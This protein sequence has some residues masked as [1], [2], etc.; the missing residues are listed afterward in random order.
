MKIALIEPAFH[1]EVVNTYIKMFINHVEQIDVYAS[2]G[3]VDLIANTE[4]HHNLFFFTSENETFHNFLERSIAPIAEQYTLILFTTNESADNSSLCCKKLNNAFLLVHNVSLS[5]E[6]FSFQHLWVY[7]RRTPLLLLKM[8]KSYV[9]SSHKIRTRNIS[10]YNNILF[11]AKEILEFS[12]EKYGEELK[13]KKLLSADFFGIEKLDLS[14]GVL[15][16]IKIV[17]PGTVESKTRNYND[18]IEMLEYIPYKDR[19][20]LVLLGKVANHILLKKIL[21]KAK[22]AK[23]IYNVD[24]FSPKEYDL[25]LK[26]ANLAVLPLRKFM[27]QGTTYELQGQTCLSGSINDVMRFGLPFLYNSE[28][29]IPEVLKSVSE[30]Y[31]DSKNLASLVMTLMDK[32][33]YHKWVDNYLELNKTQN[34][35]LKGKL[36]LIELE[37]NVNTQ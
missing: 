1:F 19:I 9:M 16:T 7:P 10:C 33:K 11:P 20:E 28:V 15:D 32:K 37:K 30:P 34:Y 23:I 36:L 18:L 26:S 13:G 31:R 24:G 25:H 4:K 21:K 14:V 6:P 17:V 12:K 35:T 27:Y 8:L 2:N 29:A 3:V 22:S 5:L